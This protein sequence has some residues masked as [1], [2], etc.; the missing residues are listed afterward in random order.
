MSLDGAKGLDWKL[1]DLNEA[2][3]FQESAFVGYSRCS[4]GALVLSVPAAEL[5][6]SDDE[7]LNKGAEPDGDVSPDALAMPAWL[8]PLLE[9]SICHCVMQLATL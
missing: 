5:R 8:R 4:P 1:R 9:V 6:S 3:A 2:P 7:F